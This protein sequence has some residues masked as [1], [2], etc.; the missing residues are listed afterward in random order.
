MTSSNSTQQRRPS[1]K[2]STFEGING[3]E[4]LKKDDAE[5]DNDLDYENFYIERSTLY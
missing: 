4:Q 3:H 2:D 5:V 1:T